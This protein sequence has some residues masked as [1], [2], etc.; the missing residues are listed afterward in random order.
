MHVCDQERGFLG[1]DSDPWELEI[2][3]IECCSM[4][5]L[6]MEP[7]LSST[8]RVGMH[9]TAEPSLVLDALLLLLV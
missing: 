9:S 6:E 8:R 7:R 4:W 3:A 2:R 1:I 5:V